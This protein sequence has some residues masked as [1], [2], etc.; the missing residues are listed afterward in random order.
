MFGIIIGTACLIGLI[1]VLR[2]GSCGYGR[3]GG[4]GYG[5]GACGS[6]AGGPGGGACGGGWEG[7]EEAPPWAR[8]GG[9]GGGRGR[10]FG[11]W[12]GFGGWDGRA[13]FLRGLFEQLDTTPGQEKVIHE[14]IGEVRAEGAKW[15]EELHRSRA[16]IAKAMRSESFDEVLL[17]ELFARHDA[18]LEALRKST[19]GAL[20]KV[21]AALDERQRARLAELIELGPAGFRRRRSYRDDL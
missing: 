15:R 12:G 5:G 10:G 4:W 20:A 21:H 3:L 7:G 17:G 14:A 1:K 6:W 18:A 19:T 2:R 11:G 16:D 8:R 9:W 13:A